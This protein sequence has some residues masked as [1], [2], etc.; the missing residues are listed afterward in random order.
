M[1]GGKNDGSDA[2]AKKAYK[3]M[4]LT[5]RRFEILP[6][7]NEGYQGLFGPS[8]SKPLKNKDGDIVF[9][10]A[11]GNF[12]T[13]QTEIWEFKENPNGTQNWQ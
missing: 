4:L 1:V 2:W 11:G 9:Y 13:Q 7:P 6:L 10:V 12:Q 5:G 8:M 3:Y